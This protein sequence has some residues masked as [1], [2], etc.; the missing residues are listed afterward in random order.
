M[1][2]RNA[3]NEAVKNAI[4]FEYQFPHNDFGIDRSCLTI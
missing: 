2:L 4:Y 1:D 3:L